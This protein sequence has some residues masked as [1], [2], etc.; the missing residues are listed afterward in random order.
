MRKIYLE[1]YKDRVIIYVD[2]PAIKEGYSLQL[3]YREAWGLKYALEKIIANPA[4]KFREPSPRKYNR[5]PLKYTSTPVVM[6][7]EEE[8]GT[9]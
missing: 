9:L 4:F 1:E 5:L 8:S 6:E 3:S 2:D 7:S